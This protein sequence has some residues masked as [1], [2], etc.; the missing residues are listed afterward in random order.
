MPE[1]V[2]LKEAIGKA[3]VRDGKL[4]GL[5]FSFFVTDEIE[6]LR[7]ENR[8]RTRKNYAE[9]NKEKLAEYQ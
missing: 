5:Q 3:L 1:V 2:L 4:R 8:K 7:I 9:R 6:A